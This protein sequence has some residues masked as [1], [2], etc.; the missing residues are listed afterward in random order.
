MGLEINQIQHIFFQEKYLHCIA[1]STNTQ[2]C[3][4]NQLKLN[5]C[6]HFTLEVSEKS[7]SLGFWPW[8]SRVSGNGN[9]FLSRLKKKNCSNILM[10]TIQ[11]IGRSSFTWHWTMGWKCIICSLALSYIFEIKY[12]CRKIYD[13]G[14]KI[15]TSIY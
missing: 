12:S 13:T 3:R 4:K 9:I 14:S 15:Y 1:R 10:K 5:I 8:V 2:V 7:L 6:I 11:N